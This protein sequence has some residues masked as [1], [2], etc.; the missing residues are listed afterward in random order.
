[1][2]NTFRIPYFALNGESLAS[3][4]NGKHSGTGSCA[5]DPFI[6][7]VAHFSKL[8]THAQPTRIGQERRKH[9]FLFLHFTQKCNRQL[10][11]CRQA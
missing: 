10:H 11:A 1:M 7:T 2:L 6:S 9:S 5:T 8:N 3:E 4:I